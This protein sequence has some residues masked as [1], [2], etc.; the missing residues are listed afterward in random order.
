[1]K[2][3]GP[4]LS[5]F[6][7][8]TAITMKLLGIPFE[9][10]NLNAYTDKE[11]VRRYSPMGKVPALVLDN[12]EVL[13]DSAGIIDV[14]HEM[15][16]PDK[17]LIPASGAARLRA[18]QLIGIG[19]NIYP[20]LTALFDESMRPE[21]YRLKSAIEGFAEQAIIGLKLLE[22]QT[23]HGWLVNDT[24]SQADIMAVVCYQGA[25]MLVL[26][27]QVTARSF[28]RLAALTERAMKIEAFAATVPHL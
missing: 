13:I 4:W 21:G 27:E 18:L 5:G 6:T 8:R 15:A 14:L 10:L 12:G 19:L 3:V 25:S 20:K 16:G 26:P 7:R 11:E 1:M 22:A 9:H 23:G 17:A 24:L 28:P 2:L